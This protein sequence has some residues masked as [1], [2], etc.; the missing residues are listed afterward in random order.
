M[1]LLSTSLCKQCLFR[2]MDPSS[3]IKCMIQLVISCNILR[4]FTWLCIQ[5]S[6]FNS[7]AGSRSVNRENY[8]WLCACS[9]KTSVFESKSRKVQLHNSKVAK[10]FSWGGALSR[11]DE[12][13]LREDYSLRGKEIVMKMTVVKQQY[14]HENCKDYNFGYIFNWSSLSLKMSF[15][16]AVEKKVS[17]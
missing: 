15:L 11:Q 8:W 10:N 6:V 17:T 2:C 1:L 3:F 12:L 5:L 16:L 7:K 13:L 4:S 14:N 9:F